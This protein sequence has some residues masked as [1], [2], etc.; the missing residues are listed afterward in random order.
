M[1][2]EPGFLRILSQRGWVAVLACVVAFSGLSGFEIS[3]G[4]QPT[5]LGE[6]AG[7]ASNPTSGEVRGWSLPYRRDGE[8]K[9]KLSGAVAKQ[10]AGGE[11]E[12]RE[13]K[14]ETFRDGEPQATL[15]TPLCRYRLADDSVVSTNSFAIRLKNNGG[16][17]DGEGFHLLLAA[18][19]VSSPGKFSASGPGGRLQ[20]RGIGFRY[21]FESG[22]ITVSN[23][24]HALI[25]VRLPKRFSP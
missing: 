17:L 23:Q 9:A 7:A 24:V 1:A 11:L 14:I 19:E 22:Q 16:Q 10:L 21:R 2:H 8:L 18:K 20:L 13:L 6:P 15:T 5:A 25:P 12:I 3:Q 4:A